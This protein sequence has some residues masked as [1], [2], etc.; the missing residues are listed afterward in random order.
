MNMQGVSFKPQPEQIAAWIE[1]NFDFKPR[2]QG[3]EYV[4]C[5]PFDGD[6][7]YHFN[8]SINKGTCHDW[9]GDNWAKGKKCTFIRFVQ[10]YRKCT[11]HEALKEVCGKD[12]KLSQIYRKLAREKAQEEEEK[13]YDLALPPGSTPLID[14]K[15]TV[16]GD[17]LITW[18]LSRGVTEP[19]VEQ[20]KIHAHSAYVVWPYYEYGSLVYWQE[21]DRLNK[22][23][24]FPD[25]S[26]G[27]TKGMFLYGF[28]MVEP[29]DHVGVTEAIFGSMTIGHQC[30]ATGGA[31]MTEM[32]VRKIRAL[33]P[34]DGVILAPDNDKAG[35]ASLV[36][37]YKLLSPY[38]PKIYYSLPPRIQVGDGKFTKDWNE[39]G[40]EK[41]VP[42]GDIRKT[43]EN[44]IRPL[45]QQEIVK[46]ILASRS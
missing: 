10:L 42:W 14:Q 28:D 4:I 11:W 21:R 33:D 23:F 7:G 6:A 27:A 20:Y 40:T 25:D 22:S 15:G 36:A 19:L 43:Y 38:I 39:L 5:N 35:K 44:S 9:R 12:V 46:L 26:V 13:Q 37:N 41:V 45:R 8:I 17:M 34:K 3:A 30:V 32:Q 31:V 24:R 29:G 1:S 18:L 2:K 16:V